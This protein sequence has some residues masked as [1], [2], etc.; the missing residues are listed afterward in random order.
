MAGVLAD[1]METSYRPFVTA[2]IIGLLAANTVWS[3]I[4]LGRVGQG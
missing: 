2:G 3:L 4:A 1:L